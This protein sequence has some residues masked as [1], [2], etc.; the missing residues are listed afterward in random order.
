MWNVQQTWKQVYRCPGLVFLKYP[1]PPPPK[2][3]HG[4][5]QRIKNI[6]VSWLGPI[7]IEYACSYDRNEEEEKRAIEACFLLARHPFIHPPSL[8][9]HSEVSDLTLP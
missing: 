8:L 7:E 6:K 3:A 5:A 9:S 1:P 4:P 2:A